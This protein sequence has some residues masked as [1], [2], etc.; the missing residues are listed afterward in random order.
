MKRWIA[1]AGAAALLGAPAWAQAIV[2]PPQAEPGALEEAFERP[3]ERD[4]DY[5]PPPAPG[6]QAEDQGEDVGMG[7]A[8]DEG[9]DDAPDRNIRRQPAVG[10]EPGADRI[11]PGDSQFEPVP[12]PEL[13]PPTEDPTIIKQEREG[14]GGAVFDTGDVSDR[15]PGLI[16]EGGEPGPAA[17]LPRAD[18]VN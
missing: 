8:G 9:V 3:D 1:L 5:L 2:E 18:E 12:P 14:T 10:E 7:G 13:T 6:A 11:Q 16:E 4:Q 17:P 15:A